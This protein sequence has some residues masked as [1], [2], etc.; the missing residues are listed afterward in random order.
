MAVLDNTPL[1]GVLRTPVSRLPCK[2]PNLDLLGETVEHPGIGRGRVT[3]V[4]PIT[5]Q[6]W[7]RW[8]ERD[9]VPSQGYRSNVADALRIVPG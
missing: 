4:N 6:L 9:I 8:D 1:A 3:K 5:G 7:I 2:H